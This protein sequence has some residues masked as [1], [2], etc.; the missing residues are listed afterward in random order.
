MTNEIN[1]KVSALLDG[2]LASD[3]SGAFDQIEQD[4]DL[5]CVW[6]RYHLIGDAMRGEAVR[7]ST[8]SIADRVRAQLNNEADIV[9]IRQLDKPVIKNVRLPWAKPLAGAALAA[10]VAILA[11]LSMPQFSPDQAVDPLPKVAVTPPVDVPVIA[12]NS[13]WRT[14]LKPKVESKLNRYLIEHNEF[15]SARGVSGVMPY[16]SFVS[17]GTSE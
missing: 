15:A 11:V 6:D 2:E 16:T 10:S 3:S 13:Q 9:P 7:V 12:S 4:D 1:E 8:L 17:Y 14:I 5:R